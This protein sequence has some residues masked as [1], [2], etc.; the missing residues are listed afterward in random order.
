ML[1]VYWGLFGLIL[2]HIIMGRQVTSRVPQCSGSVLGPILFAIDIND[3]EDDFKDNVTIVIKNS[4]MTK[5]G[6][7]ISAAADNLTL[8]SCLDRLWDWAIRWAMKFH[9]EKCHVLHLGRRN[10]ENSYS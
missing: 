3:L 5:L 7:E 1:F 8:Q 9:L 4:Q 10:P 2:R 6:Q